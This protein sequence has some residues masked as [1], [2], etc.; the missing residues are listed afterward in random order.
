MRLTTIGTGTVA[1]HPSRVCAAHLVETG[2]VRLLLDCGHGAVHRMAAL[3][4]DWTTITH[5]ALTHFHP[6]HIGDLPLLVMAWRYGTLPPRSAPVTLIG[7]TGTVALLEQLATALGD[8]LRTP[9]YPLAIV[10][11]APEASCDLAGA[12]LSAWKV[13][14]TEESVAYSVEAENRRL[15]YTGDTGFDLGLAEW[16]RGTNVLLAECSLPEEMALPTHLTPRQC[17]QLARVAEPGRLVL[18]HF[19]PPVEAA[20][21]AGA[22]RES[23]AGEV[24]LAEDGWSMEIEDA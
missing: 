8:W 21:I 10:E 22:V 14:H 23:F 19:Y 18:T 9:E 12:T 2:D 24:V 3:G 4:I 11:L 6:D 5:V 20:D 17:G 1:P 15:V 16:A 13:P 7:P